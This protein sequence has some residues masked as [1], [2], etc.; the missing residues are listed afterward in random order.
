MRGA[1]DIDP[2]VPAEKRAGPRGWSALTDTVLLVAA[3]LMLWQVATMFIGNEALTSPLATARRLSAIMA[4]ADFPAH[5]WE[6]GRAFGTALIIALA[7]GLTLGVVLG[8]HRLSGQVAEP[9]LVALYSIPKVTLYPV[10]LLLFGLGISAKIAFGVIHGIIPVAIFTMN[11][12]RNIGRVYFRSACA[13][14]L[15]AMQ[16][17]TYIVVPAALPEIVSGFRLGFSLTLLGTLIGEMF[18]SQRG[19]GYMLVKAM[20]TNDVATVM[21]L[22]LLLIVLAT[23]AS[24]VLLVI[25]RRLHQNVVAQSGD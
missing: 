24:S 20:E 8:A 23:A 10:I 25:D 6:T 13:M 21:A 15:R 14:R 9:I 19:I 18:A 2:A 4:D 5:A 7:G 12:V 11:G 16:T 22:A 1:V 3:M 17:A